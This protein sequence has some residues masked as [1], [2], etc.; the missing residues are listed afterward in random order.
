LP[1][2]PEIDRKLTVANG[3]RTPGELNYAITMVLIGYVARKGLSYQV[4]SECLSA[5]E[6]AKLEFYRRKAGPYEDGAIA[7]NGDCY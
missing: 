4:I 3:P 5:C 2:I 6:G 1:Y 7:R